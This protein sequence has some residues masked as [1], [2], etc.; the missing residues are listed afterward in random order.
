MLRRIVLSL[1]LAGLVQ[2]SLT[3]Q[4]TQPQRFLT[5]DDVFQESEELSSVTAVNF[6]EP[7]YPQA[8]ATKACAPPPPKETGLCDSLPCDGDI[9]VPMSVG[10]DSIDC[11]NGW[12]RSLCDDT[13]FLAGLKNQKVG[14]WTY[15]MGG[16]FRYRYLD[17]RNRL[18]P[19]VPG[20]QSSYHQTRFTPYLEVKHGDDFTGYVQAIDAP[21]FGNELPTLPIDENRADLLQYYGDFKLLGEKNDSLRFRVG[22]QFLKYGSQ[23]LISPLGWSNTFRNFEGFKMYYDNP[24]WSIDAFATR[25]VNGAAGNIYRPTSYDTPDQS[26]WFSGVYTTWKKA[27]KG[28]LDMYWLWLDEDN[29]RADR[30]D[31]NRHT[32]GMRYAGS[33]GINDSCGDKWMTF[34][35]DYEGAF[36]VGEDVVGMGPAQDVTAGFFSANN[37]LTFNQVAWTPTLSGIF[38]WGSGDDDPTDGEQHTVSTLFPLGHAYWGLIDNFSGQNLLDYSLQATVKPTDKLTLLS[39]VHWFQKH[40]AEDAIWNVAG[41]PFGGVTETNSRFLGTEV[42][43]VATY[44]V[45]KNLTLQGG[46]FWFFYGGAVNDHPTAAVA[47]RDDASQF[48]FMAD[49]KF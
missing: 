40:Q 41:A 38:Y 39:A 48:Y 42:D 35:W 47:N 10:C 16:A 20:R 17:E 6:S 43:L 1:A 5:V 36:Q 9:C 4:E 2:N 37:G 30:I 11:D 14:S 21:T 24:N 12:C 33:H 27:P 31:G 22:R 28:S 26:R 13:P 32:F 44:A 25:P 18:R 7:A 49:W 19:P 23:H 15:S 29:D 46:Y 3:A 8:P 45:N 34:G